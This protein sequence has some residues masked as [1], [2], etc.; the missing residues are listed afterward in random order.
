MPLATTGLYVLAMAGETDLELC[1]LAAGLGS[2]GL[3][4][5]LVLG[6][7]GRCLLGVPSVPPLF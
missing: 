2:R 4:G 3:F 6:R 5:S 1:L 7:F